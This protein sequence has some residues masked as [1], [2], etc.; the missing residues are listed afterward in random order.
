M[1]SVTQKLAISLGPD[2]EELSLR[3]GL[4]SGPVT[5]GVLRGQKS[6]F[7]LFGDTVNTASR[8]ESLGARDRIHASQATADELIR[9]GKGHW[10]LARVDRVEVKGKGQMASYWIHPRRDVAASIPSDTASDETLSNSGHRRPSNEATIPRRST[11]LD[12]NVD[13]DKKIDRLVDWN[14]DVLSRLLNL[15]KVTSMGNGHTSAGRA[16][17]ELLF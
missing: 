17:F 16:S 14:A 1:E 4:N 8:M 5:A 7:Q 6:R 10:A 11:R 12:G 9:Q 13:I 3:I 2:T 15:G